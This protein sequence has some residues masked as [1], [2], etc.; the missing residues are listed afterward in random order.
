[1]EIRYLADQFLHST[2]FAPLSQSCISKP[3]TY[4]H[5][6]RKKGMCLLPCSKLST[7]LHAL[8]N[9][10]HIPFF[11][12]DTA[13][14]PL[15]LLVKQNRTKKNKQK[16]RNGTKKKKKGDQGKKMYLLNGSINKRAGRYRRLWSLRG[17]GKVLL[18]KWL[19][20]RSIANKTGRWISPLI[21]IPCAARVG[22][23]V[24]H[25]LLLCAGEKQF[26]R[27]FAYCTSGLDGKW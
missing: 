2:A 15:F 25:K 10:G 13:G 3:S 27:L 8:L 14:N 12:L 9:W 23:T 11:F 18:I 19:R 5:A 16:K 6:S 24:P 1:M 7:Y 22:L 21:F 20:F 17:D 4:L 26:A